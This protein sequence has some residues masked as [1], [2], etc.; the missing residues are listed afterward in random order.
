MI[1]GNIFI[2][3]HGAIKYRIP[4]IQDFSIHIVSSTIKSLASIIIYLRH[5]AQKGD[6]I[7]IDEPEL[8]LHPV[9]QRILA[10]VLAGLSNAGIKIIISTHSDYITKELSSMV[11]LGKGMEKKKQFIKEYELDE[12]EFLDKKQI[13]IYSF[14]NEGIIKDI[15]VMDY[16][17]EI[18][19]F[20]ETIASQ[21]QMHDKI[22]YLT[23]DYE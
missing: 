9:N 19:S 23:S 8:N 1:E 13:K 15:P 22:Y 16:G 18:E 7:F 12:N 5:I 17:I 11:L 14:N 3:K 6:I 20:D 2:D 21:S 4:D 10:K